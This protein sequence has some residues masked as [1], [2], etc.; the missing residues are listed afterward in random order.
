MK[1]HKTEQQ[2]ADE[3]IQEMQEAGLTPDERLNV[4]SLAKIRYL[5]IKKEAV[6]TYNTKHNE[7]NNLHK[8]R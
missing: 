7:K 4:I 1:K 6:N 5:E 3:I 8:M 2:I